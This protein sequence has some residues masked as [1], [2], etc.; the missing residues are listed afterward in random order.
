MNEYRGYV[1]APKKVAVLA[2]AM[3]HRGTFPDGNYMLLDRDLLK[4]AP[5]S[6]EE[7]GCVSM[8]SAEARA[9]LDGL[10]TTPLPEPT[11]PRVTGKEPEPEESGTDG[12]E[13][14]TDTPEDADDGADA[15]TAD[16]GEAGER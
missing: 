15:G 14:G 4:L 3:G 13:A 8:D 11:D 2:G 16:G 5:Y 12:E 9:E 1:K 7:L 6:L 10:T